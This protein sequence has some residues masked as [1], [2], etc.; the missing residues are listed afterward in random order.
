LCLLL[1]TISIYILILR[2]FVFRTTWIIDK[3]HLDKGFTEERIDLNIKLSTVLTIAV[4][5]IGGFMFI[6]SLPQFCEQTFLFFQ[7]K[8]IFRE[9][10]SSASI[11]FHLIKTIIGYLLMTNSKLV[12]A[13]IDKQSGKQNDKIN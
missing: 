10:P 6:D 3:L 9:N 1:L 12:V 2:F 11:I 4:I 7:Q 5:V 13:F 8:S